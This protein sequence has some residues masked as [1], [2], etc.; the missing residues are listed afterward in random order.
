MRP[1]L[2][3][4]CLLNM[5][6]NISSFCYCAGVLCSSSNVLARRPSLMQTLP[7]HAT[8]LLREQHKRMA[9]EDQIALP[10]NSVDIARCS[11]VFCW[12]RPGT[13]ES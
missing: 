3:I 10:S 4:M 6:F 2:Q 5:M 9:L 8:T 13:Y 12:L 7:P 11:A 1:S